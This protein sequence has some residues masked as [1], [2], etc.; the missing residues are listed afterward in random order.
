MNENEHRIY[1]ETLGHA[2]VFWRP[3]REPGP[4]SPG[5][6]DQDLPGPAV[7]ITGHSLLQHL[8]YAIT[9]NP[10]PVAVTAETFGRR[11]TGNMA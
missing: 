5:V 3:A 6:Q 10:M 2:S 8:Y 11:I 1:P 9:D 4:R 7:D